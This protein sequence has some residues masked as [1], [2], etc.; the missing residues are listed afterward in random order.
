MLLREAVIQTTLEL[1]EE[2]VVEDSGIVGVKK[3][4]FHEED[5]SMALIFQ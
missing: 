1:R 3:F 2:K 4:L 5:K